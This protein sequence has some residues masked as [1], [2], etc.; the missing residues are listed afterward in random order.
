MAN[1]DLN[2]MI[3]CDDHIVEPPHIWTER[4]PAEYRDRAPRVVK[5]GENDFWEF[6]GGRR[7]MLGLLAAMG[8]PPEEWTPDPTSYDRMRPGV[9]NP[10]ERLKDMDAGGILAS[11]NFGTM[12]GFCGQM[13]LGAKDK[14]LALACLKVFNDWLFEEWCGAD[15]K[16]FIPCI[17]VPLWDVQAAVAEVERC[18]PRGARAIA[19]TE[20]LGQLELPTLYVRDG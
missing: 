8:N 5:V 15:P 18:V 13:W 17:Q 10:E 6:E 7:P 2:W 12:T 3:S 1:L 4:L 14:D 19:F 11:L 16:R 9:Y 20:N